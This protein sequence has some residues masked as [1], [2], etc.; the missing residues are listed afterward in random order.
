M[1]SAR[2]I[3]DPTQLTAERKR[4]DF[5]LFLKGRV[6]VHGEDKS[7]QAGLPA[8]IADL[9]NKHTGYGSFVYGRLGFVI[10]FATG[11]LSSALCIGESVSQ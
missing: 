5:Y 7:Q 2:D 6:I 10:G 11:V 4:R 1:Y 9:T 8:A 3:V